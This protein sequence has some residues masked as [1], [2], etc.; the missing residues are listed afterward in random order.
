MQNQSYVSPR[1]IKI[2]NPKT[3]NLSTLERYV[4]QK[5]GHITLF[6]IFLL[7]TLFFGTIAVLCSFT[8]PL[9]II[10]MLPAP[11]AC[12]FLCRHE[13]GMAFQVKLTPDN[14]IVKI[15]ECRNKSIGT[16]QESDGAPTKCYYLHFSD[17]STVCVS[18]VDF[19]E[20]MEGDLFYIVQCKRLLSTKIFRFNSWQPDS[21]VAAMIRQ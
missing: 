12:G 1:N 7:L 5:K 17:G 18:K 11:L 2:S 16:N 14:C 10:F 8:S 4:S 19:N 20:S 15:A 6:I 21:V 13:F 9:A 3:L